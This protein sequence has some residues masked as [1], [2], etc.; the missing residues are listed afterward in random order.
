MPN[1]LWFYLHN[2][3]WN[4]TLYCQLNNKYL[5]VPFSSDLITSEFC[6]FVIKVNTNKLSTCSESVI[7]YTDYYNRNFL[8]MNNLAQIYIFLSFLI[9]QNDWMQTVYALWWNH[10]LGEKWL[11]CV[12]GSEHDLKCVG[13]LSRHCVTSESKSPNGLTWYLYC[14]MVP[15]YTLTFMHLAHS[16]I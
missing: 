3:L 16:S 13:V 15:L 1:Y 2:I 10:P 12:N 4:L 5:I 7:T 14:I 6:N 9:G 11:A 8:E